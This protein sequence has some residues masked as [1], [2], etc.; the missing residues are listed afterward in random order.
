MINREWKTATLFSFAPG[1]DEYGQK[2]T[3]SQEE[4]EIAVILKNYQHSIVSD[5]RFDDATDLAL[6]PDKEVNEENEIVCGDH[7]YQVLYVIPSGR[8]NQLILKVKK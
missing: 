7:A 5:V 6:T 3:K 1:T 8:L 2:R 4:R